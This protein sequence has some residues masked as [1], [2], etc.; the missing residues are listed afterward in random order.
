MR[1]LPHRSQELDSTLGSQTQSFHFLPGL[2]SDLHLSPGWCLAY[3]SLNVNFW[4]LGWWCFLGSEGQ[5]NTDCPFQVL[6]SE[7]MAAHSLQNTGLWGEQA[8]LAWSL[9]A[10]P[11]IS[12]SITMLK[13]F[14]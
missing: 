9:T 2:S 11:H 7:A 10:T 13:G 1:G 12:G 5:V 6:Q 14:S 3:I 8:D 4:T